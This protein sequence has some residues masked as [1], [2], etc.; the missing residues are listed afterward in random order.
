MCSRPLARRPAPRRHRAG[1]RPHRHALV[2]RGEF[3]RSGAVPDEPACRGFADGRAVR[4]DGEAAAGTAHKVELAAVD[5]CRVG[6]AKRAHNRGVCVGTL[7]FAHATSAHP[8]TVSVFRREYERS[9][10]RQR[11]CSNRSDR[12]IDQREGRAFQI[13]REFVR[14]VEIAQSN[15]RYYRSHALRSACPAD[16]VR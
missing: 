6:K 11:R 1:H 10:P 8:S 2:R 12:D 13:A 16:C 7:R 9:T 14:A 5:S 15:Q 3:A 4:G